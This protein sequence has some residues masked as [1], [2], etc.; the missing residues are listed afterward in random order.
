ME[1]RERIRLK[2]EAGETKPWTKDWVFTDTYFC[3][4]H[5][6]DDRVTRWIRNFYRNSEDLAFE[7]NIAFSRLINWPDTLGYIGYIG[8]SNWGWVQSSLEE[9]ARCGHKV[10][11]D[12]YIVSTNGRAMPK[13]QYLAEML[14]PRLWEA[15][16]PQSGWRATYG[17]G[18]LATAYKGLGG[19]YGLGSFM[20]GQLL[21]DLKNTPG[22]PLHQATDWW[23]F[24]VPGPGSL[25]GLSWIE[26]G[27]PDNATKYRRY[28]TDKIASVWGLLKGANITRDIDV[29]YQDLQNCLCEFDKYCRVRSGT[30]RSKRHY[31]GG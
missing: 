30:G 10:W 3:N 19:V 22:H 9:W 20:A 12:A 31:D 25:R 6:E 24:T 18:T 11:G 2:K 26:N 14:L 27:N 23:S 5:R 21:A 16:G 7:F 29:C 15:L 13:A 4:V 1:E 8:E 28:F 17:T